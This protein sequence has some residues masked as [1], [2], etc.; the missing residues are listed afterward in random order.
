MTIDELSIKCN[1]YKSALEQIEAELS[2][3]D[4]GLMSSL[5]F[6]E[7]VDNI[8]FCALHSEDAENKI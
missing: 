7:R 8:L 6:C 5:V 1:L 4:R 2:L 3:T